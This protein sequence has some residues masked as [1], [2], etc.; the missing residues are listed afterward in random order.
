MFQDALFE[1]NRELNQTQRATKNY[2]SI[3]S[4][5]LNA[6][7]LLLLLLWPLLHLQS[8]PK[9]ALAMLVTAPTPPVA[10]AP[11]AR[12]AGSTSAHVRPAF[13]VNPLDS[14]S[15]ITALVASEAPPS[16]DP[17]T[18]TGSQWANGS[19]QSPGDVTG[20]SGRSP[21]VVLA[22]V[23]P[24]KKVVISS[25]VMA[26]NRIFGQDPPYPAIARQAR[27][28]GIVILAATISKTGTIENLHVISGPPLLAGAAIE[29]VKDWRY[30]P[31]LLNQQPVEVETTIHIVFT[32]GN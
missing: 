19:G 18:L 15:R 2:L 10:R 6:A 9:Q 21:V 13:L 30:R 7:L 17:G 23:T 25:G 26:G 28:E 32:L 22:P 29:A 8:L 11:M 1:S 5:A 14:R 16:L 24:P 12:A 31:Y 20:A 3:L 27:I 4:I